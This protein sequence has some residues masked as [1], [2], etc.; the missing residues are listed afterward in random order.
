MN[1]FNNCYIELLLRTF[2]AITDPLVTLR[3]AVG[4]STHHLMSLIGHRFDET[5]ISLALKTFFDV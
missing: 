2:F 1:V 4:Q 5:L 3:V